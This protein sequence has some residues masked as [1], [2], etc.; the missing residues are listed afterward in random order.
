MLTVLP[1]EM[2]LVPASAQLP[3]PLHHPLQHGFLAEAACAIQ[4][5]L[6]R[7][8]ALGRDRDT[9]CPYRSILIFS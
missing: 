2:G 6:Q 7:D 8:K 4:A 9:L 3:P 5:A 1:F